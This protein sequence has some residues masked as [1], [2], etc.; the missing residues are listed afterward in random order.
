MTARTPYGRQPRRRLRLAYPRP[1]SRRSCKQNKGGDGSGY[2]PK[3]LGKEEQCSLDAEW[4]V[5]FVGGRPIDD[6]RGAEL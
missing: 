6:V 5:T 2:Q 4:G 1:E 3:D